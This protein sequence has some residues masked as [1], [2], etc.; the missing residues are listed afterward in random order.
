[1]E[2]SKQTDIL[3][4]KKLKTLNSS[5]N[6]FDG[7]GEKSLLSYLHYSYN[8]ELISEKI[9]DRKFKRAIKK[10]LKFISQMKS[11]DEYYR[12]NY[13]K[14][15]FDKKIVFE[16]TIS[17]VSYN[18]ETFKSGL[19]EGS[20][21]NFRVRKCG[22][23]G[24]E[25]EYYEEGEKKGKPI[26][27]PV[28]CE[29]PF[30]PY[31][32]CITHRKLKA[33][34]LLNVFF[35]GYKNWIK[36][37]SIITEDEFDEEGKIIRLSDLNEEGELKK[38]L[39]TIKKNGIT[40]VLYTRWG[41]WAFGFKRRLD[42]PDRLQLES[43]RIQLNKFFK[44]IREELNLYIKGVGIRDIAYDIEKVGEE[45]FFHFH[46]A[47]RPFPTNDKTLEK[48][49][50]IGERYNIKPNFIGYRE[51]YSLAD[52]FAKRH[53]GQFEHEAT[54]TNWMYKDIMDI[55][56]YFRLFYNS[57]KLIH[58]GFTNKELR[59]LKK[60]FKQEL[61]DLNQTLEESLLSPKGKEQSIC[62]HC[63]STNLIFDFCKKC[64]IKD[65]K[66]PDLPPEAPEKPV[67]VIKY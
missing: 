17:L 2:P 12:E 33:E 35:W 51:C 27:Y 46:I 42:L 6:C 58:T 57:R 43:F 45:Y 24:K 23:C 41:H 65:F 29:S 61:K 10:E 49:N 1:M 3:Q 20:T 39:K 28:V 5:N 40:K 60:R 53:S 18:F 38:H 59:F 16:N 32:D 67:E 4:E 25:V 56:T 47:L 11:N 30:C 48:I 66:P 13:L 36:E 14:Y 8:S 44:A 21:Q 54:G 7:G 15:Q 19:C 50:K 9:F 55:E 37:R 31:P 52:Y 34:L 62:P 64:D 22:D 26:Y 63:N